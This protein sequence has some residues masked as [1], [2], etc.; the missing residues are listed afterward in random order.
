MH[1]SGTGDLVLGNLNLLTYLKIILK[2]KRF[3]SLPNL[4]HK[5]EEK[6]EQSYCQVRCSQI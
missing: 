2:L 5:E 4:K 1:R 3:K 6:A